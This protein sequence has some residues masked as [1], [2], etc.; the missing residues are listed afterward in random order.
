MAYSDVSSTNSSTCIAIFDTVLG[1]L[2]REFK[3]GV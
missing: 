1:L 3:F 2:V